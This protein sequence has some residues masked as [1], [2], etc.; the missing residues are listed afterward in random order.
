MAHLHI[1]SWV[2]AFVMLGLATT[3]HRAG[4]QKAAK[5]S[6]MILRA[7]YLLVLFSGG[8]LF[9]SY[10]NYGPLII[11]K[12]LAGLWVLASMEAISAKYKKGKPAGSWWLQLT[13]AA[14]L[15]IILGWGFLPLGILPA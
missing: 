14:I 2:I 12:V 10:A 15:A 3:F 1:T 5:I 8:W 11:I 7:D 9:S 6:Q 4:K 13:I